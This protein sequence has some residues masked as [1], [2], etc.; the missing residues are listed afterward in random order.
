MVPRQ[1]ANAQLHGAAERQAVETFWA[2]QVLD[3]SSG[4]ALG[5]SSTRYSAGSGEKQAGC[6]G[7]HQ[8]Q[9]RYT[10]LRRE[11]EPGRAPVA[12][13][14]WDCCGLKTVAAVAARSAGS[15]TVLVPARAV[16][17]L[18]AASALTGSPL[19]ASACSPPEETL[20]LQMGGD[21][22]LLAQGA[23]WALIRSHL[24]LDGEDE[25]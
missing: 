1:S 19:P 25:S 2:L 15:S 12:C 13:A 11:R 10:D 7:R 14:G 3:T 16:S 24:A 23:L 4:C 6:I 18:R 9:Q 22:S 8:T 17:A 20:E 21:V 5:A